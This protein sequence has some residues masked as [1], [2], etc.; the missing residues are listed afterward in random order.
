MTTANAV[1]ATHLVS[2]VVYRLHTIHLGLTVH[3]RAQARLWNLPGLLSYLVVCLDKH[4]AGIHLCVYHRLVVACHFTI[5]HPMYHHHFLLQ[6]LDTSHHAA[7]YYQIKPLHF[8]IQFEL[9][10][11]LRLVQ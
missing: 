11:Q 10:F 1:V 5:N 9:V 4:L 2:F 6:H 8:T 3:R 7:R